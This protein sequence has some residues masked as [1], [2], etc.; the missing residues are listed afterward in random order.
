MKKEKQTGLN[1]K[2]KKST[3]I[4]KPK[5]KGLVIILF[6]VWTTCKSSQFIPYSS[7]GKDTS[8]TAACASLMFIYEWVN[9]H[10]DRDMCKV[11]LTNAKW[12]RYQQH[13]SATS[14]H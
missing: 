9:K 7:G 2:L 5:L 12:R 13:F 4:L 6:F 11:L 14:A 3:I 10:I 8:E 1:Q